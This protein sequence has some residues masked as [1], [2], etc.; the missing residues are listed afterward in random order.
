MNDESYCSEDECD[1]DS[2][3]M[4][5]QGPDN[6]KHTKKMNNRQFLLNEQ[7]NLERIIR[8]RKRKSTD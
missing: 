2:A 3:S 6:M 4:S 7:S 8:K 1:N 5:E